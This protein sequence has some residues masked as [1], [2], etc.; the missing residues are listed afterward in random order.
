MRTLI[1]VMLV[2]FAAGGAGCRPE[3]V[4]IPH[5][6][7]RPAN[8]E[9][10]QEVS[11][12]APAGGVVHARDGSNFDLSTLWANQRVVLVFYMGHW[13]PHC[14][15]QLGDLQAHLKDFG[16]LA[17]TVVA[18]S[19]DAPDDAGA[20]KD[21]LGLTFDLYSDP[22]LQVIAK[23]GVADYGAN[24]SKPATFIIQKGGAITFRKVGENQTD[25]PTADQVI[26][27]LRKPAGSA[28]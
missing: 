7:S 24:I 22:E 27:E 18:V 26:A 10:Q 12:T 23:W 2:G 20:L 4:Q 25:R 1:L 19:T 14:Q 3:K 21:K 16:E 11:D 28:E 6:R 15:R 17:T 8:P 13:C 9:V 5:D